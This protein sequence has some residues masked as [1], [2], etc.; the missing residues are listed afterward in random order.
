MAMLERGLEVGEDVDR[1]I[2]SKE[3]RN[4]CFFQFMMLEP[5]P[6][7]AGNNVITECVL[8]GMGGGVFVRT[9]IYPSPPIQYT[10]SY[11]NAVKSS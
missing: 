1:S 8:D 2:M 7:V 5:F 11:F 3:V 6:V 9:D 10:L 4:L